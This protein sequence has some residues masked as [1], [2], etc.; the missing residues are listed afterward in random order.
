MSSTTNQLLDTVS[1][2]GGATCGRKSTF[3]ERFGVSDTWGMFC[4]SVAVTEELTMGR[5]NDLAD[6]I[7]NNGQFI[8]IVRSHYTDTECD[9]LCDLLKTI[10]SKHCDVKRAVGMICVFIEITGR[11]HRMGEALM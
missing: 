10:K 5:L 2:I 11:R 7:K 6:E 8:R 4:D 9:H 1:S 3:S